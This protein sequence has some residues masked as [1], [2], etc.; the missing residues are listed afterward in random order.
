MKR[1]IL[2]ALDGLE[3]YSVLKSEFSNQELEFETNWAFTWLEILDSVERNQ[4][5]L[6]IFEYP[7][8]DLNWDGLLDFVR[9]LSV[10]MPIILLSDR[11]SRR[12]LI[13][14]IK[15][16][17][18]NCIEGFQPS[19]ILSVIQTELNQPEN[20]NIQNNY[21]QQ[22]FVNASDDFMFL[23]NHNFQY[24]AANQSYPLPMLI[25]MEHS[26]HGPEV[27]SSDTDQP[28]RLVIHGGRAPAP[29]ARPGG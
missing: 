4:P 9:K 13:E 27:A 25:S 1:S 21:L 6:L 14:V 7:R 8:P 20:P 24:L 15:A 16:G 2:I 23:K 5:Q 18:I 28:H 22:A 19:Q 11:L 3:L 26:L 12:E 29:P 17:A 10:K